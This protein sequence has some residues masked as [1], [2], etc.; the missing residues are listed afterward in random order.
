MASVESQS[1][2][3]NLARCSREIYLYTIPHLYHSIAVQEKISKRERSNGSLHKLASVLLRRPELGGLVRHFT[4]DVVDVLIPNTG[5]ETPDESGDSEVTYDSDR[6]IRSVESVESKNSEEFEESEI[7]EDPQ[8]SEE[9]KEEEGVIPKIFEADQICG[10]AISSSECCKNSLSQLRA[11]H[12]CWHDVILTL[13]L[14][15]LLKVETV[16]LDSTTW[17][18]DVRFK[19]KNFERMMRK[20]VCRD[21]PFIMQ[22][23]FQ[24]LKVFAN[25]HDLLNRRSVGLIASLLRLPAIQDISGGYG[26]NIST[27]KHLKKLDSSSSSLTSLD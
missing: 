27:S 20:V 23:P 22:P 6:F 7:P 1:T 8:D 9:E 13:L 11:T 16:V 5:A 17:C 24:A 25:S 14:P 15:T 3:C 10:T 18:L 4:L 21:R 26:R 2:L 19:T 12:K